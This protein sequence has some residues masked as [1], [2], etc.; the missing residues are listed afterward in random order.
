MT[1]GE[2][3]RQP[4]VGRQVQVGEQHLSGTEPLVLLRLRFL[5][6]HDHLG[7]GEHRIGIPHDLGADDVVLLVGDRG[8]DAGGRLDH[9]PVPGPHELAHPSGVAATRYSLSLT[10]F[11]IP[12]STR[13]RLVLG[14]RRPPGSAGA[15]PGQAY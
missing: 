6:L 15:L 13:G 5:D 3:P 2:E 11:G 4:L 9:H 10:S 7:C 1:F 14:G 12:T 8:S